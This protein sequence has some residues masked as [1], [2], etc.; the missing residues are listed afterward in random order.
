MD[1][2]ATDVLTDRESAR[3]A[4]AQ[5]CAYVWGRQD[6]GESGKDTGY[7]L[8]FADAF[9]ARRRLYDDEKVCFMPNLES[10]FKEWRDTGKIS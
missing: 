5:A 10:A 3:I 4:H 9:R 6:A 2:V 1:A 8:D 7:S